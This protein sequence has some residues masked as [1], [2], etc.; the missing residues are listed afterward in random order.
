MIAIPEPRPPPSAEG[1]LAERPP[2]Q[3]LAYV[4]DKRLTGSLAVDVDGADW[5]LF[6][7]IEGRLAKAWTTAPFYL[8]GVLYEL[9][10][11]E[12]EAQ[13]AALLEISRTRT[14]FGDELVRRGVLSQDLL[15]I[16]LAE[17]LTR[18]LTSL[19]SL[20]GSARFAY[21][22]AVDLLS[23]FGRDDV[24]IP[25]GRAV[26]RGLREKGAAPAREALARVGEHC[27]LTLAGHAASYTT[28]AL[29]DLE[30][31]EG[32]A[33]LELTPEEAR[34]A[35]ALAVPCSLSFL[36]AQGDPRLVDRVIYSLLL[37]R[38]VKIGEAVRSNASSSQPSLQFRAPMHLRS[39]LDDAGGSGTRSRI[40][41]QPA[42]A[43]A[44]AAAP[45][46]STRLPPD[47]PGGSGTRRRVQ[48]PQPAPVPAAP[49]S[50]PGL[51]APEADPP[52][53]SAGTSAG[54]PPTSPTFPT[55]SGS[56]DPKLLAIRAM[57]LVR[58]AEFNL[59]LPLLEHLREKHNDGPVEAM[60]GWALANVCRDAESTQK[61]R[62]CLL[63]AIELCP[64]SAQS[65][66]YLA[67]LERREGHPATALRLLK[68]AV[69]VD[70]HHIDAA[71]ELRLFHMRVEKGATPTRAMSP[72]EGTPAVESPIKSLID[73]IRKK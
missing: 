26:V 70:P 25:V 45:P 39:P 66:Y 62:A 8:G 11:I 12:T 55:I 7:F 10:F 23:N 17:Q 4:D 27:T 71:R 22:D 52:S 53:S 24:R 69:G 56:A 50:A 21:H 33:D 3:L 41:G 54:T 63:K 47:D 5:G 14:L 68:R 31:F 15:A 35:E 2:A 73:K 13:N 37:L 40:L 49:A 57:A 18:K 58:R 65:Y 43:Q 60:Y 19:F 42:P 20:P 30:L 34:V 67:L 16:G 28:G 48:G 36:R 29:R 9:G 6:T 1:T 46:V 51:F 44:Q 38:R 61:A 64:G 59:A 32:L 72:A